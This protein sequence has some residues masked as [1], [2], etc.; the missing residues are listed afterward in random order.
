[1]RFPFEYDLVTFIKVILHPVQFG[2]QVCWFRHD[3]QLVLVLFFLK[4]QTHNKTKQTKQNKTNK[5][6]QTKQN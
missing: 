6:K 3:K 4:C 5:T 2:A 1:M